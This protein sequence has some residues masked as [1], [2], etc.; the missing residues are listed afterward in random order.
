[1][2][3]SPTLLLC[4][5]LVLGVSSCSTFGSKKNRNLWELDLE[6]RAFFIAYYPSLTPPQRRELISRIEDAKELIEKWELPE[7]LER[8]AKNT[9]LTQLEITRSGSGP[10][11]RGDRTWFKATLHYANGK[12]VDVT[13]DVRWSATPEMVK[14]KGNR[15]DY[16]CIHSDAVVSAD[17]Y[18]QKQG[19]L[20]LPFNKKVVSL[21]LERSEAAPAADVSDH[22]PLK[23]IAN[24]DDG[25]STDVSCQATW[26][27]NP[28]FGSFGMCGNLAL[29]TRSHDLDEKVPVSVTYGDITIA[30]QFTPLM[31]PTRP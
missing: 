23:V 24:C 12:T 15:L 3:S 6:Q 25:T 27:T 29:A 21:R 22:M 7:G 8:D 10:L 9:T 2:K 31:Y 17:F 18:Y 13:Q 14:I 26:E 16:G 30:Q 1:M 11:N 19:S 4:I 20:L 5:A 28:R